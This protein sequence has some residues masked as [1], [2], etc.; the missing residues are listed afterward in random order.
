MTN[1]YHLTVKDENQKTVTKYISK[2]QLVQVQEGIKNIKKVGVIINKISRINL[3]IYKILS[4]FV[5]Q[6]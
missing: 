3:E 4:D 2:K 1:C 6:Q 5:R